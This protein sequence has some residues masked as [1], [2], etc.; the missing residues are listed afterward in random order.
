LISTGWLVPSGFLAL[1]C[2]ITSPGPTQTPGVAVT[3]AVAVTGG[4]SLRVDVGLLAG[5]LVGVTVRVYVRSEVGV[6]VG[7]A[8]VPVGLEPG[9]VLNETGPAIRLVQIRPPKGNMVIVTKSSWRA[10]RPPWEAE[11]Y[12]QL[13]EVSQTIGWSIS[14]PDN[15]TFTMSPGR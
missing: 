15:D 13:P 10:G 5:E 3:V 4:V 12:T 11:S 2:V 8:G 7:A 6:A 14:T 1:I 9:H